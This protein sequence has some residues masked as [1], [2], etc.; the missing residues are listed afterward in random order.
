MADYI[1]LLENRLS[2]AQRSALSS[3][4]ELARA[5]N[6][7]VF[8]VGGAVR[9]LTS[10]SP[11]RDLDVVVQGNAL[12]LRADLE[13]LGAV[14]T[15]ELAASQAL[16]AAFPGS[17]RIEIGSTLSATWPKPGKPVYKPAT[18]LED[19]RRRDFTANA[20]ALSLNEGSYGL[21]MDPLNGIADIENR[22]LRLVS[23][24]GFIEDPIRMV[25]AARLMARLGWSLDE[26]TQ[27]RYETGKSENYIG[28]L[29]DQQR[30]YELE[31]IIHEEDPFRIL[32]R[33]EA[34]GWLP[35][36][37]P[38]WSAAKVD[39]PSLEHLREVQTQL[40]MQGI[41]PDPSA[42]NFP[43]LTAKLSPDD[44]ATLKAGFVRQG[45]V[46]EIEALEQKGKDLANLLTSKAAALPSQ[47]WQIITSASPEAVLWVAYSSK[48]AAI[49]AKFK[50][51]FTVWPQARQ[52]IPYLLMQEMRIVPELPVYDE[53]LGKL[54]FELMDDK[55]QTP[56]ELK[57][58]LE[59]FSPPA[60]PPPV[61]TR[62]PR[63]AKKDAKGK[64][65]GKRAAAVDVDDDVEEEGDGELPDEI[66]EVLT[67]ALDDASDESAD[68][69]KEDDTLDESEDDSDDDTKEPTHSKAPA[70][71]TIKAA[72]VT[73]AKPAPEPPAPVTESPAASK[74]PVKS[75]TV[76]ATPVKTPS[77][78]SGPRDTA[79]VKVAPA[80][81]AA[82]K[83]NVPAK[84]ANA[85]MA[86]Q[87]STR[88]T[89]SSKPTKP[90]TPS[91]SATKTVPA[92]A[93]TK[94]P[95]K[96]VK[97]VVPAAKPAPKKS[98]PPAPKV[99]AKKVATKQV[100]PV[101]APA[102]KQSPLAKSASKKSVPVGKRR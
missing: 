96:S 34:E 48:S 33:L 83:A 73:K 74:A 54:F 52:K 32:T 99:L 97:K 19:L 70:K 27:Q 101:K 13:K 67:D 47:T 36:L 24:Y 66:E 75:V 45:F 79:T 62:R 80:T 31:E 64:G 82:S 1:Y 89:A 77:T 5:K 69:E 39:V 44:V 87:S 91:K 43:L 10:G 23:N 49:Q 63:A 76:K 56:D 46:K 37:A 8:L 81:N 95:A 61:T 65:R 94:L 88:A 9:D 71:A 53:L 93:S 40:Q 22:E 16:F 25:R 4:R 17:V 42:A 12:K 26:K 57:A 38:Y 41:H 18:I 3:V 72:P 14:V 30:G 20:M 58:F 29:S 86:P 84:A 50:N 28:A 90:S 100:T 60:P 85:V 6:L 11:V 15:G 92:R 59:P 21:L 2:P 55:L 7:T 102:K 98:A 68:T 78:K 51:F 35:I